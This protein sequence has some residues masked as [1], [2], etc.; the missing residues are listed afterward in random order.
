MVS[1][2]RWALASSIIGLVTLGIYVAIIVSEGSNAFTE[3]APWAGTMAL[4]SVL[5][6]VGA[7]ASNGTVARSTL[8]AATVLF[9]LLG[10]LAI[11]SIGILFLGASVMSAVEFARM[12]GK[13]PVPIQ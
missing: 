5:A 4:A 2:R 6:F 12:Q 1:V 8:L 10:V 3:V 13:E 7:R 11:F 9:G